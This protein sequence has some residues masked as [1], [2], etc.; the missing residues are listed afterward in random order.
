MCLG[1]RCGPIIV[2]PPPKSCETEEDCTG[3]KRSHC[4]EEDQ[5]CVQCLEDGH[6]PGTEVCLV[7][8]GRCFPCKKDGHCSTNLCVDFQC[9]ACGSDVD[10]YCKPGF[11]CT[12]GVCMAKKANEPGRGA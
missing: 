10:L 9:A 3:K 5:L 7:A 2:D 6:C 11:E 12:D 1:A 8:V 4:K